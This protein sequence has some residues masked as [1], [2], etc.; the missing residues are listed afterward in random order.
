MTMQVLGFSRGKDK[1]G[2]ETGLWNLV[3]D[4]DSGHTPKAQAACGKRT[5]IAGQVEPLAGNLCQ[6]CAILAQRLHVSIE[7]GS[8]R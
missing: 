7:R 8:R 6:R 4:D 1:V 2:D 5:H 3:M